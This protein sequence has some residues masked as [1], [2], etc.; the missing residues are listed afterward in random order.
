MFR[1]RRIT[2]YIL[3]ELGTATL[4]GIAVWTAILMMNDLFFI[5][6]QAIQK[7]LGFG[8]VLQIL[9]LKVPNLL[10][11]SIPIGTLL[12]SLIAVGRL[13]ADGEIVAFQAAGLGPGRLLRPMAIHGTLAFIAAL[14]IYAFVQ[15]WASYELRLMQS[16]VLNA[17]N[18]STELRPR[19]FFDRLPG[20]VLFVDEI[21]PGTTGLLQRALLY[22]AP[23]PN[24]KGAAEKLILAKEANLGPDA[25]GQGRLRILFKDGVQHSYKVDDPDSYQISQFETLSP[26][27]LELPAWMRASDERPDKTVTDMTPKELAAELQNAKKEPDKLLKG[28]R[29]HFAET[30]AH[31]RVAL[32]FASFLFA[33]LSLP[34]GVSRVRSGKGAGF[35]LSLVIV[36][37]YYLI[38]TVG[39]E[40][41]KDGRIP[42]VI[43]MW[44][45]NAAIL[46]WVVVAFL[47]MRGAER[48]GWI[49]SLMDKA[50]ALFARLA[51]RRSLAKG[52]SSTPGPAPRSG[53][54]LSA[55]LDRYVG[56]L[57]LRMLALALASTYLIFT[58]LEL[59]SLIDSVLERK[60]SPMLV[61]TY[62]KYFFPGVLIFTLPF[63]TLLAAVVTL[64]VLSR[65][66]EITALKASGMSARRICLPIIFLTVLLCGVLHLVEDRIAPETNRRAQAVKDQIQGRNPRTYGWT[67]GGRWTFGS[68]GRLYHYRLF[69]SQ[70]LRFQG[71]TVYRVDLASARVLEQWFCASAKWEGSGWDVE[72]GWYRSFPDPAGAGDYR[73]FEKETISS[74]DSPDS[75]TRRERTLA[76]ND[77]PEQASL[78]ELKEEIDTLSQSGYDTTRLR[79]QYWQKTSAVATPLVTVLLG[80]PFAFKVGRRGSMYGVGVGLILAIVFWAVAAISNALGLE[81]ILPPFLSAWAPNIVFVVIGAYLL[82]LAPT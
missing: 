42:A 34:L 5:A 47:R 61:I 16:R 56:G 32:P 26:L 58:L 74:F 67:P 71:L 82:L 38:F 35:A 75:F 54:R 9:G 55:I 10:I 41:A 40:Q 66:G 12:G 8:L 79:V 53:L 63:A 80:L 2:L 18:V 48:T 73:R 50:R 14:G 76:A 46:V 52:R 70:N 19:V 28:Y 49:A 25:S 33:L 29:L 27:P 17:R 43:G 72:K 77:I 65:T 31:R 1:Q 20:Y 30:E 59:K 4:V 81:T 60:Q 3:S 15:P 36:L 37:G 7:D 23:D 57:Y 24:A 13:S 69:D 22:E 6:R 51:E 44:A 11:L 68:E 62:F 64:T 39:L 78:D 45:G 21:P